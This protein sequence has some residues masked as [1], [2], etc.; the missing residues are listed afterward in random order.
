MSDPLENLG[1]DPMVG[2]DA[3][4]CRYWGD[5]NLQ[6][7]AWKRERWQYMSASWAG[8]LMERCAYHAKDADEAGLT[9]REMLIH[10]FREQKDLTVNTAMRMGSYMEPVVIDLWSRLT[11]IPM[12]RSNAM[13]VSRKWARMS[14]TI[15]GW[16]L[17]DSD[18]PDSPDPG[19]LEGARNEED[20]EEMRAW[21]APFLE[22][23]YALGASKGPGLIEV[24]YK[25]QWA[26]GNT[27]QRRSY[28][29]RFFVPGPEAHLE[30]FGCPQQHAWQVMHQ[31]AV[32]GVQWAVLGVVI[33]G[34][35]CRAWVVERDPDACAYLGETV[36]SF[37]R[38]FHGTNHDLH[39]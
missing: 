26:A 14:C 38:E 4:S 10:K 35:D 23:V 16:V 7:E 15:D 21:F 39:T 8:P 6:E 27:T 2:V 17:P 25:R 33:G 30:T 18:F 31:M 29:E 1:R 28:P 5:A 36:E 12:V 9:E 24:K 13:Y 19:Y 11:G 32:T 37:W 22:R 20:T 34:F 3:E